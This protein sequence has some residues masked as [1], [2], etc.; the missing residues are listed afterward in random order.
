MRKVKT[1]IESPRGRMNRMAGR[2]IAPQADLVLNSP[3]YAKAKAL[4]DD[5]RFRAL[6][7]LQKK[8]LLADWKEIQAE[9]SV[10]LAEGRRLDRE[11]ARLFQNGIKIDKAAAELKQKRDELNRSIVEWSRGRAGGQ[12]G[13]LHRT[14]SLENRARAIKREIGG[15]NARVA[16]WR[17]GVA[18]LE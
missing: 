8:P 7:P 12:R 10:L 1:A 14:R 17:K 2:L 4:R 3:W 16:R 5:P 9:R 6:L 13:R 18:R 11:A 15:H